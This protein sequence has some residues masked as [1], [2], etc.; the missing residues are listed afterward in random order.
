MHWYLHPG[1][2]KQVRIA[3][4]ESPVNESVIT[5]R[6][7]STNAQASTNPPTY[8]TLIGSPFLERFRLDASDVG[9]FYDGHFIV[10]YTGTKKHKP[11]AHIL[12]TDSKC[13]QSLTIQQPPGQA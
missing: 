1:D 3:T 8:G 11:A 9:Y 2:A 13:T 7:T 5:G 10:I 4:R 6:V 12:S